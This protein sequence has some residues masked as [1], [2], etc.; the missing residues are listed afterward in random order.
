MIILRKHGPYLSMMYVQF[1]GIIVYPGIFLI[2]RPTFWGLSHKIQPG[3]YLP[4]R[5]LVLLV[6][7][8]GRI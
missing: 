1:I 2:L 4:G 3:K 6:Q 5:I 8:V 7:N